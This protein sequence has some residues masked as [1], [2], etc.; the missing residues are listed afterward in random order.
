MHEH[1]EHLNSENQNSCADNENKFLLLKIFLTITICVINFL[2]PIDPL[3]KAFVYILAYLIIG[4]EILSKAVKNILKGEFFDENFLMSIATIGA[5]Y[6]GQEAESVMVMLLYT[7]GEFLQDKAV[8]KS[9][10]SISE[11]MELK[12]DTANVIVGE[13]VLEKKPE[14]VKIG[15]II[16]LKTGERV[17]L[18]G[19]VV[20]GQGFVE[21]SALSGESLPKSISQGDEILSGSIVSN[22]YFKVRVER[23]YNNSTVSKIL[24]LVKNSEQKKSKTENFITKFAKIYTPI[25]V[26]LAIAIAV[27]PPIIFGGDF[28]RWFVRAL[29][30]I[31]IS[32]PCA[33]VIS[34]PLGF[35]AGLGGAS[36]RGILIKGAKYI[37]T[38]ANV[39]TV[40]FDKTG[41]LTKGIFTLERVVPI[42][43]ISEN[44][45]L[46]ILASLEKYSAHPIANAIISEYNGG[47]YQ[48]L[49]NVS[50]VFGCG[51]KAERLGSEII[52]G[53]YKFMIENGVDTDEITNSG[54]VIYVAL[55]KKLIGY[56]VLND[57]LK[58]ETKETIAELRNMGLFPVMLSGDSEN[59]VRTVAQKLGIDKFYAKLLP[60]NKV[61]KLEELIEETDKKVMFVGDGINDAPVLRRADVGVAMGALGSDC[62][63][64]AA[65]V[66]VMDDNP[67]KI[68]TA[69][70]GSKHTLSIVKQNIAFAILV[71]LLFLTLGACGLMTIWG[72]VFSDV[73]VT[74]IA[75][76]NS[77]RAMREFRN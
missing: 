63:I 15:D 55:D 57:A 60:Q 48:D 27:I 75:V 11:L 67:Q 34:V 22:G 59:N 43:D 56:V 52:T 46:K 51:V 73:G 29:I 25:V 45:L 3:I 53:N 31:V 4:M 74:L 40:V 68:I 14:E 39:T 64:E 33:L 17:P 16:V 12:P 69:I 72:A 77:L 21:T 10:K 26:F 23:D 20:M 36:R 5:L 66:V 9:Q 13:T 18:D 19:V 71:K 6:I 65:D 38:L 30:F 54:S 49:T 1:A 50:E 28:Y 32:C 62:A 61:E 42:S 24:E 35:F 8:E 37:E 41:T 58:P 44:E 2:L 7:I 70:K 76:L 47:L